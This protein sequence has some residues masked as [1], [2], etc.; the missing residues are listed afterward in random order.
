M[1][2]SNSDDDNGKEK[3]YVS[4]ENDDN[5]VESKLLKQTNE[6]EKARRRTRGP[7]RKSSRSIV[8]AHD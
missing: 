7:Y 5:D 6:E 1:K 3:T 8:S 4:Y 2:L